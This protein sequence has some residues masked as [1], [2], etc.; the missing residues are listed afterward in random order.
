MSYFA[1][2][3]AFLLLLAAVAAALG[4]SPLAAEENQSVVDNPA[5]PHLYHPEV[6][7]LPAVIEPMA[8]TDEAAPAPEGEPLPL[9][10]ADD[11]ASEVQALPPT[12][13]EVKPAE[14][15]ILF[16]T[17]LFPTP[18]KIL[19]KGEEALEKVEEIGSKESWLVRPLQLWS[20]SF[21]FGVSGSSGNNETMDMRFASHVRR[22]TE[23][24]RLTGD[25]NYKI[26]TN[27]GKKITD[28]LFAES[29]HEWLIKDIPWTPYI[30]GTAEHDRVQ[31]FGARVTADGGF[32]YEFYKT[33]IAS[34]LGRVGLGASTEIDSPNDDITYEA[35]YGLD[36]ERKVTA[37]QRLAA[38]AE[39]FPELEEFGNFRL[40]LKAS[41]EVK[42]DQEGNLSLKL[43]VADRY[44]STPNEGVRPNDLDYAATLLWSF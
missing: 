23:R 4:S 16:D 36:Y 14:G 8:L 3:R 44:D 9:P 31:K 11:E 30:H 21:E 40:N 22:E 7:R 34:L 13:E 26:V 15:N 28:R 39:Y 2:C 24:R 10:P 41:W 5:G 18:D 37:R 35:V 43:S 20:A 29:R 32:G 1:S 38:S 12:G 25:V 33:D 42:I 19:I 6:R 17:D 27:K